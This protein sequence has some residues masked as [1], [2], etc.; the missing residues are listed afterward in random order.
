MGDEGWLVEARLLALLNPA[1]PL[2]FFPRMHLRLS[3]VRLIIILAVVLATGASHLFSEAECVPF[4][5]H[6]EAG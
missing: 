3:L 2:P 1:Q 4:L 5:R 6:C